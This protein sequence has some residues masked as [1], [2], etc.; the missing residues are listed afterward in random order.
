MCLYVT[1]AGDHPPGVR[2]Y[3]RV[4]PQVPQEREVP[5]APSGELH[6]ALMRRRVCA[7]PGLWH[8][9]VCGMAGSVAW[10]GLWHGR[11]CGM[12]SLRL[13]PLLATGIV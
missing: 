2:L 5:G 13:L 4:L 3:L 7:C 8:G 1:C 9:R 6:R 12:A 10:L 11:V